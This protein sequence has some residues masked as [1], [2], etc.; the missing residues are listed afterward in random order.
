MAALMSGAWLL[1]SVSYVYKQNSG[2]KGVT[3]TLLCCVCASGMSIP[4]V[5]IFKGVRMNE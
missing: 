5:V 1:P 2:D 3:I 4:P